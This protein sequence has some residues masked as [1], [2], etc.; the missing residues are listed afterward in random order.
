MD[1]PHS[2]PCSSL[3]A[4]LQSS[5]H[6]ETP[7]G[8]GRQRGAFWAHWALERPECSRNK[9]KSPWPSTQHGSLQEIS[10]FGWL[11]GAQHRAGAAQGRGSCRPFP[12]GLCHRARWGAPS[13]ICS[14]TPTFKAILI[15]CTGTPPRV[16]IRATSSAFGDKQREPVQHPQSALPE[17][18]LLLT[19]RSS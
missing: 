13:L 14:T 19:E 17:P 3:P 10:W 12:C 4:G 11:R 15:S 6:S 8:A 9:G 7:W 16:L 1:H 5:V 18:Q 2:Q